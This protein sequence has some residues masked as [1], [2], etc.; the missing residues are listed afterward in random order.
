MSTHPNP[1]TLAWIA[2]CIEL[3]DREHTPEQIEVAERALAQP[4]RTPA[5]ESLPLA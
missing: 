2:L 1:K 4:R 5:Q 3:A